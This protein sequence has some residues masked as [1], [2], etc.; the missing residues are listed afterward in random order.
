MSMLEF[1]NISIISSMESWESSSR[2]LESMPGGEQRVGM[3]VLW[4]FFVGWV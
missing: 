4:F 2:S 3:I 1:S